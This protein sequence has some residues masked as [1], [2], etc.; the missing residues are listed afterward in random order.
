MTC[1]LLVAMVV[2]SEREDG[3]QSAMHRAHS[4]LADQHV[5]GH[6]GEK[7]RRERIMTGKPIITEIGVT[8]FEHTLRDMGTDYNGF[9]LVYQPGSTVTRT[10]AVL[11]IRTDLGITGEYLTNMA[12]LT[13]LPAFADYLMG[14]NA[15]ERERVYQDVKRALRQM[16]RL[17]MAAVDV[18]LWDIAG[19]YYG[20]PCCLAITGHIRPL[21]CYASTP[22]G[23]HNGGLAGPEAYADFAQ[24]CLEMGYPAFKI[25]G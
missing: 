5:V 7:H 2:E 8:E 12:N 9:N 14:T 19:K 23:D 25:H 10:S 17:G 6:N 22:H 4:A 15:L 13:T 16:A 1:A 18:A 24:Q 20:S 3:S 21:K 11:Q